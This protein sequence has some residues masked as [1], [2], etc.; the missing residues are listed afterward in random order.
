M[1][2]IGKRSFLKNAV[3][4]IIPTMRLDDLRFLDDDG[5]LRPQLFN[6]L[7]GELEMG[8]GKFL[9][10]NVVCNVTP[11]P[12]ASD[13]IRCALIHLLAHMIQVLPW[14]R[15]DEETFKKCLGLK[16]PVRSLMYPSLIN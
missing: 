12:G 2:I 3:Q 5:G 11:S 10:P 13:S 4:K 16:V 9:G 8:T 6:I 14:V 15:F 1:P 7:T